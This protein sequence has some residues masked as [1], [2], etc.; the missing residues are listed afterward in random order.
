VEHSD[1]LLRV[2]G[3]VMH[4]PAWRRRLLDPYPPMVQAVNGVTFD[5]RRGETFG[6]VGESGCGKS[7]TAHCVVRLHQPTAGRV[8][9]DGQDITTLNGR[10]LRRLRRRVQMVLQDPVSAL[11]P[12]VPAIT[13]VTEPLVAHGIGDARSR[14]RKVHALLERVGIHPDDARRY[15]HELSGGQCQRVA[16]A[17]A[18]TLEP[19]LL[20]LDEA[21][22]ALDVSVQAGILNLLR[23]LQREF[24]LTYLFI[25]HDLAVVRQMCDRLAVMYLGQVVEQGDREQLFTEPLHPYTQAL[26]SAIPIPDPHREATRER[27][28]LTGDVPNPADPPPGCRFHTRC[29]IGADKEICHQNAPP[30]V[31]H[32]PSHRCACHYPAVRIQVPGGVPGTAA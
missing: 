16:I 24:Q 6:L 15:P 13:S 26:M 5:V 12:R 9:F 22:S 18:L 3:L 4:F 14:Q 27:I 2:D 21:V 25:A 23:D 28:I 8:V 31:E 1:L 10:G 30:L 19:A 17:R 32:T 11:D 7:T 29:P 20:V